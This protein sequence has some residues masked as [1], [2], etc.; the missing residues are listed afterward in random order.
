MSG[1]SEGES[2]DSG[3]TP[4]SIVE[5]AVGRYCQQF[6]E[7]GCDEVN[8]IYVTLEACIAA[9]SQALDILRFGMEA[10]LTF[11]PECFL[12]IQERFYRLGCGTD[13]E[14]AGPRVICNMSF[15]T[16]GLG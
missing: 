11:D 7:C 15:G 5:E 9:E 14:E 10:G 4:E 13:W 3:V 6:I 12:A 2:G 16:K 1:T 8:P